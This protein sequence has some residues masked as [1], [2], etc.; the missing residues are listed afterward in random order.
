[1][2]CYRAEAAKLLFCSFGLIC[3][4][5]PG[6]TERGGGGTKL[7]FPSPGTNPWC[8]RVSPGPLPVT[9]MQMGGG[10]QSFQPRAGL[11][12]CASVEVPLP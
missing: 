12:P 3:I 9:D 11:D 5:Q 1:M 4:W 8:V 2:G 10:K 6:E 7:P